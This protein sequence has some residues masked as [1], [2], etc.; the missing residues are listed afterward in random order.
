MPGTPLTYNNGQAYTF[1]WIEGRRLNTV[2][3]GGVTTEYLYNVDGLRTVKKV[4]NT[5][6]RYFWDGPRTLIIPAHCEVLAAFSLWEN[7]EVDV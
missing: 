3:T 5:W 1:S 4:G 2:T 7:A 6:T